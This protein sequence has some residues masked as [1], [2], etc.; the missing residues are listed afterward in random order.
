MK[1]T[2]GR[3]KCGV[4]MCCPVHKTPR[5]GG[6]GGLTPIYGLQDIGTWRGIGMVFEVPGP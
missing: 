3:I 5:G 2:L 6:G 1:S 4:G